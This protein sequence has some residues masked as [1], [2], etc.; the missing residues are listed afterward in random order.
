MTRKMNIPPITNIENALSVYYHHAEL[1]NNEIE[2]LFGKKSS[3]T[4][5][6]LKRI[7]RD[8]MYQQDIFSFGSN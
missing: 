4:V 7:A 5:S 1:G 3:A 6:K 2:M 8:E